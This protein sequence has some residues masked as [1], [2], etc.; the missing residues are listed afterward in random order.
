[1]QGLNLVDTCF[2]NTLKNSF[3]QLAIAWQD[4]FTGIAVDNI[5]NHKTTNNSLGID[6]YIFN[7]SLGNLSGKGL[8]DLATFFSK[9]ISAFRINNI[10]LG[11]GTC[12]G[13]WRKGAIYLV[14]LKLD[15]FGI[16]KIAKQARGIM[17]QS[18]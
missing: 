17:S 18:L 8:A 15:L 3:G 14:T 2:R 5:I 13:S 11:P 10:F 1:M 6:L 12:E 16:V 9:N 7:A 4:H